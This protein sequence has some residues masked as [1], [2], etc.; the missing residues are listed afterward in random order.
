MLNASRENAKT[1]AALLGQTEDEAAKKLDQRVLV[2]V[3]PGAASQFARDLSALL[4]RTLLVVEEPGACDLEIALGCS[5]VS[6]AVVKLVVEVDAARMTIARE[7]SAGGPQWESVPGL[8]RRISAC[9]AAGVVIA[10]VVGGDTLDGMP[11]PFV[12]EYS[13][14][15]LDPEVLAKAIVLD[16]AVLAGA[17]GVGNGFVWG[18]EELAVSGSLIVVDPKDVRDGNLNRCLFFGESDKNL[19]KAERLSENANLPDLKLIPHVGEFSQLLKEKGRIATIFSTVDSRRVRRSLQTSLPIEVFDASTTDISEVVTHSHSQPTKGACLA[20]IYA[21]VPVEDQ[22][23]QDVANGLGVDLPDVCQD[24]I[25]EA[26]ARK[27]VTAHPELVAEDLVGQSIFSLFK[28]KC[29]EGT[30]RNSAGEQTLAPFAFISNLAGLLLALELALVR[31]GRLP[32]AQSNYLTLNPWRPPH[33]RARRTRP[34]NPD[35]EFCGRS[36]NIEVFRAVWPEVFSLT[37]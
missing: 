4:E 17:G 10:H 23:D 3:R 14:L 37:A 2:T 1:L 34:V 25:T 21:H 5:P 26:V 33:Q 29:A 36:T 32:R 9:Y 20:C 15:G 8:T 30:L 28:A 16:G 27:I 19:P 12:V 22:R 11:M 13:N 35:C 31:A 6:N 24:F 18:L 7:A